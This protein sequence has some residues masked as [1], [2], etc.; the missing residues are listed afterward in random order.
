ML[1]NLK[2]NMKKNVTLIFLFAFFIKILPTSNTEQEDY[3]QASPRIIEM[4]AVLTGLKSSQKSDFLIPSNGN[5]FTREHLIQSIQQLICMEIFLDHE[6][7]KRHA[8]EED[9]YACNVC[10]RRNRGEPFHS[11]SVVETLWPM[12]KEVYE[13]S[14]I[15][16]SRDRLALRLTKH[17]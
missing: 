9:F 10:N 8:T 13:Q 5:S 4:R 6:K 14:V 7:N 15:Q 12:Y 1:Y 17:D 3:S 16:D 11:E 2:I